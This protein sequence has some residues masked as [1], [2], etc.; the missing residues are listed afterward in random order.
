MLYIA[1]DPIYEHSLPE[2]HRFPMLKYRLL[3]EQLVYEGTVTEGH[4]FRP[5]LPEDPVFEL[6]HD[7]GYLLRMN[8]LELTTS[9]MRKIGFPLSETLIKREKIIANGTWLCAQKALSFGI[10][11]NIAGG[12]HHAFRDRGE[13]FCILN[14]MAVAATQLLESKLASKILILDLDVHQGNG[15]ASIFEQDNRVF[16]F[17]MHGANNYPGQKEK[18]DWDV[19]LPDGTDD[20]S[21][22]AQLD[23]VLPRLLER[24]DPDFIFYQSGVDVLASDKLGKLALSLQGCRHRDKKVLQL[25]KNHKIP[26]AVSMGGG[27]S[28]RVATIVEAHANT[29]RLAQEIFF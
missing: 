9:E 28:E 14:D 24:A 25:C 15:T 13:G 6:A 22:L 21:Y 3:P 11:M 16:T 8:R 26:V 7:V 27:Y 10:S 19:A 1:F 18:S 23:E 2:G 4:F 12:T 20:R 17:S 29:F 5:P